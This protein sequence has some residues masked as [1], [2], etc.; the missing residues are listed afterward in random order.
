MTYIF[1][2]KNYINTIYGRRYEGKKTI[3]GGALIIALLSGCSAAASNEGGVKDGT[4]ASSGQAASVEG[5]ADT[6]ES[7][8][9][10]GDTASEGSSDSE[11]LVTGDETSAYEDQEVVPLKDLCEDYFLL[12]V[13]IN[14]STLENQTLNTHS[15]WN[16]A[17]SSL[18]AVL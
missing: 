10:N 2:I 4:G 16:L 8:T 18:T 7:G 13:G 9:S 14:G 5:S 15:I 3:I 11:D 1:N 6:A 12:G 17:K